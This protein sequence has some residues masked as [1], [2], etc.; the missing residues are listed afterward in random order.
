VSGPHEVVS[1]SPPLPSVAVPQVD[2]SV[3]ET[4]GDHEADLR[5]DSCVAVG[6]F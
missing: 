2:E 6:E 3:A 4:V 5:V 1:L